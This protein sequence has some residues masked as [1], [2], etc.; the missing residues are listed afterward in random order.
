MGKFHIEDDWYLVPDEFSWNLCKKAKSLKKKGEWSEITYHRTP[1]DALRHYFY[2][3]AS[4][5][6]RMAG[7]GTLKDL[8]DLLS[9]ENKRLSELLKT[10]FADVGELHLGDDT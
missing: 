2:M 7:E 9:A 3:K 4:A 1:Q 8:I 5:T 6:A 10:A